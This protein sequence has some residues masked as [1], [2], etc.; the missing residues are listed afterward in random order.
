MI[1]PQLLVKTKDGET[2]RKDENTL[3]R[4]GAL[5]EDAISRKRKMEKTWKSVEE[6]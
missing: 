3:C 4:A 2:L 1:K 6:N 5:G